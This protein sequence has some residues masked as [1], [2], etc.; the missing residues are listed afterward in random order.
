MFIGDKEIK[1]TTEKDEKTITVE[2][3]GDPA[4]TINKELFDLIKSEEKG[5][6]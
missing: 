6:G 4:V 5:K 2:F 1:M 3:A